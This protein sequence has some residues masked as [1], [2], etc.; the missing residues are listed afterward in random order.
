H[1]V[2]R[3]GGLLVVVT[4]DAGHLAELGTAAG[5]LTVDPR[6]AERLAGTLGDE[7]D[8]V[9]STPLRYPMTL[10][11]ADVARVVGMGPAGH[12]ARP[13]ESGGPRSVTASF[14]VS[15]YRSR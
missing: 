1:R 7:F 9:D 12:H 6:K 15:R 14:V 8:L 5:L 10:P 2:L 3:P 4:P 13:V 11:P